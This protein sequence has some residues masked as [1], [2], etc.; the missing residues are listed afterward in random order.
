MMTGAAHADEQLAA[1]LERAGYFVGLSPTEAASLR[2]A[3]VTNGYTGAMHP[4]RVCPAN[5]PAM[6]AGG[7][8]AWVRDTL[9]PVL[10]YRGV[11]FRPAE[12]RYAAD[13]STYS[14]AIGTWEYEMWQAGETNTEQ[15][16]TIAAFGM[17]NSLLESIRSPQ[18]LYMVGQGATA[19]AWLLSPPQADIIRSVAPPEAWPY[20]PSADR[21]APTVVSTP[22]IATLPAAAP[23]AIIPTAAPVAPPVDAALP[24]EALAN[25]AVPASAPASTT[26][27]TQTLPAQSLPS[28]AILN[29]ATPLGEPH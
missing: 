21:V 18:R 26:L 16:S 9:Q 5:T 7:V 19:Q 15:A 8:G 22:A 6:A 27:V 11:T 1:A 2:A 28:E 29:Q 3:V 17:V 12:D 13:G 20:L 24:T 23:P 4:S 10:A 25:E 14:V